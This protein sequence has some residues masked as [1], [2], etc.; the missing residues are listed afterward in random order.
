[1][2]IRPD[3]QIY[4]LPDVYGSRI[5]Q[6]RACLFQLWFARGLVV[7]V[8]NEFSALP[9]Y[10]GVARFV[11]SNF[12]M[13]PV[14]VTPAFCIGSF[15]LLRESGKSRFF[16]GTWSVR[17]CTMRAPKE[18]CMNTQTDESRRALPQ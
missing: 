5:T 15:L 16:P 13:Y 18:L 11:S 17:E 6:F 8:C 9:F 14:P 7:S 12:P 2:E 10:D 4:P 1:M 3:G